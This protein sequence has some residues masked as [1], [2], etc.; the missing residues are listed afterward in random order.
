MSIKNPC[1]LPGAAVCENTPTAGTRRAAIRLRQ[2]NSNKRFI[3]PPRL[4]IRSDAAKP[5]I[6]KLETREVEQ[7]SMAL[8]LTHINPAFPRSALVALRRLLACRIRHLMEK[9]E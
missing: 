3:D 2:A 6:I 8:P 9:T 7:N 4:L 1:P 5:Q